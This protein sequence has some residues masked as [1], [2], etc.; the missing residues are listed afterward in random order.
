MQRGTLRLFSTAVM[1]Q[2]FLG[3][4]CV[5]ENLNEELELEAQEKQCKKVCGKL[6][7]SILC[8]RPPPASPT[9]VRKM[10][11]YSRELFTFARLLSLGRIIFSIFYF[12]PYCTEDHAWGS[13][14]DGARP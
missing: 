4:G 6:F 5:K 10:Y 12:I 3:V 11:I 7:P 14:D 1:L 9:I 2:N 8:S 13:I